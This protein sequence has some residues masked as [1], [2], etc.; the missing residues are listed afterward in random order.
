M[1]GAALIAVGIILSIYFGAGAGA[2]TAM[3]VMRA[4]SAMDGITGLYTIAG[5]MLGVGIIF[6]IIFYV[7]YAKKASNNN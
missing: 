6:A 5:I 7:V 4:A 2:D 3:G 1:V